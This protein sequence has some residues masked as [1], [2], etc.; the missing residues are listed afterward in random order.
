MPSGDAAANKTLDR[1]RIIVR[2]VESAIVASS[3]KSLLAFTQPIYAFGVAPNDRRIGIVE[4][5]FNGTTTTMAAAADDLRYAIVEGS[6]GE[7]RIDAE[8]GLLSVNN[9]NLRE[10]SKNYTLKVSKRICSHENLH[11]VCRCSR[12][13]TIK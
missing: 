12:R 5:R 3:S 8:S 6:A 4:A 7:I 1:A 9:S 13:A 2:I 10:T 11:D